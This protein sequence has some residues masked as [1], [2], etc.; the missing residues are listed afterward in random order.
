MMF[1]GS[2]LMILAVSTLTSA[3]PE[4]PTGQ[5]LPPD[6]QYGPPRKN[7]YPGGGQPGQNIQ[8]GGFG[9]NQYLPPNQQYGPPGGRAGGGYD[10]G[11]NDTPAKYE[12]EYMVNDADSGN[13]FGHKESRDGD[14]ARGI[15]YV[16]LPDGRRQTVEYIADQNGFRPVVSYMQEGT[17]NGYRNDGGTGYPSGNNGYRY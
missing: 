16:L 4:P 10:D 1:L 2:S 14:V 17:G 5:Y 8:N 12:F 15:Y 3:R 9:G 13:D 7:D 6:Q 11:Y